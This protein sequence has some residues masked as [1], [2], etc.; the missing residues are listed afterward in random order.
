VGSSVGTGVFHEIHEPDLRLWNSQSSSDLG[1]GTGKDN[2]LELGVHRATSNI[3]V[4]KVRADLS[5]RIRREGGQR[6]VMTRLKRQLPSAK[7]MI[8]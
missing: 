2:L 1:R 6:S 7:I 8:R 4:L 3:V 5:N